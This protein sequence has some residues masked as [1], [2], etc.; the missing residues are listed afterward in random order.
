MNPISSSH[1]QTRHHTHP[2]TDS[3][4][5]IL[6]MPPQSPVATPAATYE[7]PLC[8]EHIARKALAAHLTIWHN[9]ERPAE[10]DFHPARDV[11]PGRLACAHCRATF[12]MDFALKIN[13]KRASC[14]VR[15]CQIARNLH[16]GAPL[17]D[18]S[19]TDEPASKP[20]LTWMFDGSHDAV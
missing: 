3:L 1:K 12:S 19:M 9:F 16:F 8:Q 14:P 4:G 18:V 20:P 17:P 6:R 11:L 10:M 13:F 2:S 5:Q 7:C 15:L